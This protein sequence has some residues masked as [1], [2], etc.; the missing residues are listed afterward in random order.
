MEIFPFAFLRSDYSERPV[1]RNVEHEASGGRRVIQRL[2]ASSELHV[3]GRV[4]LPQTA[5]TY[6]DLRA[7][8]LAR[9]GSFEAFLYRPR[10]EPDAADA[11][12]AVSAQVDF[13]ATRRYVDTSTLVVRKNGA[14]QSLTTHY[15][16]TNGS[17]GAYVVGTSP[18]LVVRFNSAPGAGVAIALAYRFYY[19]MRFAG[20]DLLAD[21]EIH[22][23]GSGSA[24]VADR[25][26]SLQLR[27]AGPG[28]SYAA[29]PSSL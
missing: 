4:L 15:T 29:V 2:H 10:N 27:E 17:G 24:S 11:F 23:G 5:G 6:A 21:A 26:V 19:P 8:W 16:L 9:G 14:V 13:T 22:A 28:Y 7:W 18:R 1:F 3:E 12:T 25:V 20:D